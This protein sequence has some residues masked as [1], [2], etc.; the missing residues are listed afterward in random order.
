MRAGTNFIANCQLQISKC[1][2]NN[3]NNSRQFAICIKKHACKTYSDIGTKILSTFKQGFTSMHNLP[4]SVLKN[5]AA[6]I[7]ILG[8]CWICIPA[9][10]VAV[11]F[12]DVALPAQGYYNG[13][14]YS[15]GFTSGGVFFPNSFADWGYGIISWDNWA[16]SATTDAATGTV[17]NQY[18]AIPGGGANGS[19]QYAV[20]FPSFATGVSSI[21]LPYPTAID[22][23]YFTNTTYAYF[24]M[25]NGNRFAKKFGGATGADADWFKL[26]ITGK[27]ASGDLAGSVDFYLADY[28]DADLANHY[29]V[30]N[31]IPVA[32]TALGNNIKTLEFS[33]TSSDMGIYGINT[34]TYFA[35]DNLSTSAENSWSGSQNNVW[36]NA[37]N[38]SFAVAPGSSQ[39]VLFNKNINTSIN[40]NGDRN[41][42]NISFDTAAAGTFT[43]NNNT[44][45]LDSG[46]SITVA[47][48]VT[49]SQTF[50]CKLALAG[51]GFLVSDGLAS[52]QKLIVNGDIRSAASSGVWNLTLGGAGS[53]IL[54]G[55]ISDGSS[56]GA[57]ALVKQGAGTWTLSNSLD[58][59]GETRIESGMLQ[60]AGSAA[61]LHAI[62]GEGDLTVG[63]SSYSTT[64]TADSINMDTL[65]ITAGATVVIRAIPGGPTAGGSDLASVPEPGTLALLAMA[66]LG[67]LVWRK[68]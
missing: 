45:T 11:D 3:H 16:C 60:I 2:L 63:G 28:R 64:L 17:A 44:L 48:T 54:G 24:A 37:G 50:N 27:N 68:I 62:S 47:G 9:Q 58:Y 59:S 61:N 52:G 34:P 8:A 10:A 38:W 1:K 49:T 33:L 20:G 22:S 41:I 29:I 31:W 14:D 67:L 12:E 40:L 36:S 21:S 43:F 55:T 25:L 42:Q 5:A 26:T 35:M 56:G 57:L 39:N 7:I 13:S 19:A 46:G 23:A 15:G 4:L 6:F 18:S 51:N 32:F 66:A 53:G 30:N 65:T